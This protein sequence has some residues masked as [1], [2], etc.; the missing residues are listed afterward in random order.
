MNLKQF[1]EDSDKLRLAP[2]FPGPQALSKPEE[3]PKNVRIVEGTVKETGTQASQGLNEKH[4]NLVKYAYIVIE[5]DKDIFKVEHVVTNVAVRSEVA[6]GNECKFFFVSRWNGSS[7]DNFLVATQ[8]Q[9]RGTNMYSPLS[10]T[11]SVLVN[12][13][14]G[15]AVG[16]TY[17]VSFVTVTLASPLIWAH[18]PFWTCA[19]IA[20]IPAV[21]MAIALFSMS[22]AGRVRSSTQ[23]V[24]KKLKSTKISE[25]MYDGREMKVF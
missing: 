20:L 9:A 18:Y 24:H 3:F 4:E 16:A 10:F 1:K 19:K 12:L 5:T 14:R 11:M 15:F 21:L 7:N 17:V 8:S 25:E 6:I 22:G 2:A 23:L 13:Y